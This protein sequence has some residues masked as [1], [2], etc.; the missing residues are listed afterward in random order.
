MWLL[1]ESEALRLL[2]SYMARENGGEE[3]RPELL[4][5][6]EPTT[7]PRQSV[8]L[9]ATNFRYWSNHTIGLLRIEL[10]SRQ[11]VSREPG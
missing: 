7:G 1:G 6:T 10:N 11:A 4:A 5:Q 3:M 8:S 2:Y 9:S